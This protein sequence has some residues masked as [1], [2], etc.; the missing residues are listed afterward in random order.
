MVSHVNVRLAC[1]RSPP[2]RPVIQGPASH[3]HERGVCRRRRDVQGAT[4]VPAEPPQQD[5]FRVVVPV[6]VGRRGP[7]G[8][9]ELVPPE[10]ARVG[11]VCPAG[12]LAVATVA[13]EV[14]EGA[15]RSSGGGVGGGGDGV[16][17]FSA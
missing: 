4:A 5:V 6:L 10:H 13:D 1:V 17:D 3:S 11:H 15:H 2:P 9:G 14:A 12:L 16:A 8:Q 7:Q